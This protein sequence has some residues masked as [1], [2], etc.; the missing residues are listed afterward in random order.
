MLSKDTKINYEI[1]SPKGALNAKGGDSR[2]I[3]ID[4]SGWVFPSNMDAAQQAIFRR[5]AREEA[6]AGIIKAF[7]PNEAA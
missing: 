3:T 7:Q 2:N 6:Y 4:Q 5:L 1:K